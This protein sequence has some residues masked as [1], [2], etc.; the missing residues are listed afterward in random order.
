[1]SLKSLSG[2]VLYCGGRRQNVNVLGILGR[3]GLSEGNL[4]HPVPFLKGLVK[5]FLERMGRLGF[6]RQQAI[7]LLQAGEDAK[8]DSA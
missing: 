7:E 1:M 5:E 4:L 3:I 2:Q 8:R 6:D